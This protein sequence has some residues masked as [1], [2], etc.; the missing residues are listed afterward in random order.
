MRE[1]ID[2]LT[3]VL[4]RNVEEVLHNPSFLAM[5]LE[6]RIKP[7]YSVLAQLQEKGLL[8]KDYSLSV[9]VPSNEAFKERFINL[10]Q[11]EGT[12]QKVIVRKRHKTI[13]ASK[14]F[15]SPI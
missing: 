4:D 5:S 9:F 6:K 1:K 7:R 12:Q 15:A 11:A 3:N 14:E 8:E 13:E 10:L 2:Y